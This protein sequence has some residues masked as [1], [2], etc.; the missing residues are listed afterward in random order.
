MGDGDGGGASSAL[1]AIEPATT[2]TPEQAYLRAWVRESVAATLRDVEQEELAKGRERQFRALRNTLE[3]DRLSRRYT[4]IAA[5]LNTSEAAIKVAVHRLR[6][7][8]RNALLQ[9]LAALIPTS[10][11]AATTGRPA[12]PR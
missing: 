6:R 5:E 7:R 8:F 3:G 4:D 2:D 9:R 11:A 12:C 1:A 10:D